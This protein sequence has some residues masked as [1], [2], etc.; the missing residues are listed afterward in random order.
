MSDPADELSPLRWCIGAM[1]DITGRL[2]SIRAS[3]QVRAF[4]AIAEA[5][6]W[7]TIVDATL[8][9]H[10]HKA[11]DRV[12]ADQPPAERTLVEDTLAGLR[13]VRNRMGQDA[14]LADFVRPEA[15]NGSGDNRLTGWRWRSLPAPVL[16]PLTPRGQVWE[17]ARYE[18]Y[19]ERLADQSIADTFGRA[20]AF[21]NLTA[22]RAALITAPAGR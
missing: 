10:H 21:L 6:W 1:N 19:Q 7:V 13:F 11:Y 3:D 16:A 20:A 17:M 15:S 22:A 4:T 2:P 14:D 8:L 18:A 9:R 5:V 12:M